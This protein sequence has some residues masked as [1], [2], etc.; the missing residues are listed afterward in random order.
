MLH[1]ILAC[2]VAGGTKLLLRQ[3]TG[4]KSYDEGASADVLECFLCFELFEAAPKLESVSNSIDQD[5]HLKPIMDLSG[6]TGGGANKGVS[7]Q[8]RKEAIKAQV[9]S[10][11]AMAN[12]QN[13]IEKAT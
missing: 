11:L 3:L 6:L 4:T 5:S 13:L 12:A 1:F 7:A 2:R 9:Q 10:E 8:E